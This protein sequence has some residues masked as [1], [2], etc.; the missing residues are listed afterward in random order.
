MKIAVQ[1][2]LLVATV[3]FIFSALERDEE[4]KGFM[5]VCAVIMVLLIVGIQ[6]YWR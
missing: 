6:S 3:A 1:I 5:F 4:A 2:V